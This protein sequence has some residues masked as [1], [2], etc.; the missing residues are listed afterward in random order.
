MAVEI[1]RALASGGMSVGAL[2]FEPDP[3]YAAVSDDPSVIN[4][5]GKD[6]SL[7]KEAGAT[8]VL[9][10]RAPREEMRETLD[11]AMD[12]LSAH[13]CVVVEGNSA[14]EVLRPCIV[15]FITG[16]HDAG[17]QLKESARSVLSLAHVLI[18]G[19]S[20]PPD[21]PEGVKKFRGGEPGVYTAHVLSLINAGQGSKDDR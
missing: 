14:I 13:D 5:R 12:R 17:P 11:M 16:V 6:T 19:R 1:I 15:L 3:L 20:V 9:L 2:K 10:V 4:S 7:M 8:E 21:T 18:H